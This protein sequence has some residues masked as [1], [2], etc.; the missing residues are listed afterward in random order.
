[1]KF[2]RLFLA[3]VLMLAVPF[4]GVLA[5]TSGQCMALEHHAGAAADGHDHD[6]NHDSN[7]DDQASNP[8]CGPCVACCA[9]AAI[10]SFESIS[11]PEAPTASVVG[12][13]PLP[14]TGIQ[15]DTL[16]RPPLAL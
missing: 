11:L 7:H 2:I 6:S 16:D 1:M 9:A 13:S 12:A 10:V 15:P 5:V 14:F 3:A 4:Q 8:H